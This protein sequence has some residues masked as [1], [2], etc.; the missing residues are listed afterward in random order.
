MFQQIQKKS[1]LCNCR[2]KKK[3]C[4][5]DGICCR[6]CVVYQAEVSDTSSQKNSIVCSEGPFKKLRYDQT[7]T[8]GW[9][10]VGA[11][12]IGRTLLEI[13]KC[14]WQ[15]TMHKVENLKNS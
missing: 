8:S 4:P 5:L 6:E 11:T 12:K 1:S 7:S 15:K 10:N 13:S 2:I 9:R 3:A 14:T